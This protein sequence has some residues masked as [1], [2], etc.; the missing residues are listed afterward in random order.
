[1]PF[2]WRGGDEGQTRWDGERTGGVEEAIE[3]T[4]DSCKEFTLKGSGEMEQW[5]EGNTG[6]REIF[7]KD[8]DV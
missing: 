1:M 7:L 3:T 6:S 8:I 2:K 4:G 5:L